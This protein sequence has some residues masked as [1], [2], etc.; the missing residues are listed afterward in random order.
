MMVMRH[1]KSKGFKHQKGKQF[2]IQTL[3]VMSGKVLIT[4]TSGGICSQVINWSTLI[5]SADWAALVTLFDEVRVTNMRWSY[6]PVG[7]GQGASISNNSMLH[8]P[9][10]VSSDI[11]STGAVTFDTLVGSRPLSDRRNHFTS[12]D[13]GIV[14]KSFPIGLRGAVPFSGSSAIVVSM[15]EWIN[16]QNIPSAVTGAL[17]IGAVTQAYNV[18]QAY[19]VGVVEFVCQWAFRE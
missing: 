6:Q 7:R 9:M 5:A 8:G 11:D 1:A 12:T 18:S 4:T 19:G 10:F 15:A 3:P 2:S 13:V 17:Q 14:D 16:C